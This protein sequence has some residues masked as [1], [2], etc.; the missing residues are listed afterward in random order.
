M[1]MTGIPAAF[2]SEH[3]EN[4]GFQWRDWNKDFEFE[5]RKKKKKK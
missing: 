2:D 4:L 5:Q 3:D 1:G